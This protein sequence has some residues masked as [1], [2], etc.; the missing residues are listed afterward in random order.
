MLDLFQFVTCVFSQ[1][2]TWMSGVVAIVLFLWSLSQKKD[3]SLKFYLIVCGIFIFVGAF[4][5]W[6]QER[7]NFNDAREELISEQRKHSPRLEGRI[8]GLVTSPKFVPDEGQ[9]PNLP[10]DRPY[11][12]VIAFVEI[13]NAGMPSKA[14]DFRMVVILNNGDTIATKLNVMNS[15]KLRFEGSNLFE[16]PS[17]KFLYN[18]TTQRPIPSGGA[19][20]GALSFM[21]DSFNRESIELPGN[22]VVLYFKDVVG[23]EYSC[24]YPFTGGVQ[25]NVIIAG[26]NS[27]E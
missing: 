3:I 19:R 13:S 9:N 5:A 7:K 12:M 21:I 11:T 16:I 26:W 17:A 1:W 18:L 23:K 15:A 10:A 14:D 22:R 4:L 27:I 6:R 24:D 25:W 2:I 8:K 20:L